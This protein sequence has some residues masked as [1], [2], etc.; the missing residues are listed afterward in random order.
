[1]PEPNDLESLVALLEEHGIVPEPESAERGEEGSWGLTHTY[2]LQQVEQSLSYPAA[3][4]PRCLKNSARKEPKKPLGC[5]Y[6]SCCPVSQIQRQDSATSRSP[7]L[8]REL[9]GSRQRRRG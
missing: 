8:R 2:I 3:V 7:N 4:L 6:G 5:S 1:M 9:F